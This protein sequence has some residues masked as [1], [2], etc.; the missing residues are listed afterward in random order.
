MCWAIVPAA[1]SGLRSGAPKNKIFMPLGGVPVLVHTLRALVRG[2]IENIVLCGAKEELSQLG[3]LCKSYGISQV[4]KIVPGGSTRAESVYR[5]LCA[6]APENPQCVV[7]HDG[8]RPLASEKL[9]ASCVAAAKCGAFVAAVPAKDTIKQAQGDLVTHTPARE[10]LYAA[11]TP[12]GGP[13]DVVYGAYVQAAQDGFLTRA[14]DDASVCEHAGHAVRILSGEAENMK[15]TAPCDF[16]LAQALLGG[17]KTEKRT[18]VGFGY[19]VHQLAENR[20]LILCGA[21]IS[22]EKGLLG[23]SD[24]DVALHALMDAMLGAAAL[25]DIGQLFPDSDEAYRGADSMHLLAQVCAHLGKHGFALQNVDV[26]IIAQRPK[27][28]PYN[29]Q[30]RENIACITGL[31]MDCVSVKATTTEKLG[32]EGRGE[33][34]GACAVATVLG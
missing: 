4:K 17:E 24:A 15:I 19:D 5:A 8:A 12:Q 1:G 29:T 2:G 31:P 11:Q 14:T 6:I 10:T 7:V 13:F 9:I 23:H 21:E 16:A 34:I 32:F 27:L 3:L 26:T 20:K 22:Y 28:L 18:R 30:M 33:G 25:G